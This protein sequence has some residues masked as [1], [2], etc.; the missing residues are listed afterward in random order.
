M[1]EL[2]D[3]S[4][5]DALLHFAKYGEI[6]QTHFIGIK[7]LCITC[8]VLLIHLPIERTFNYDTP[9]Y[10]QALMSMWCFST[11]ENEKTGIVKSL[12]LYAP[13]NYDDMHSLETIP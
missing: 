13:D 9:N 4:I 10:V 5:M 6:D 7:T 1:S 12:V 8:K 11:P 3:A 2:F